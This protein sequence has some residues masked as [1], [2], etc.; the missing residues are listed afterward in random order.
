VYSI[1]SI[2]SST[3]IEGSKLSNQAVEALLGRLEIKKIET[4]DE[5]EVAAIDRWFGSTL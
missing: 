3:R 1:E 4:Q 5:Q 2:G